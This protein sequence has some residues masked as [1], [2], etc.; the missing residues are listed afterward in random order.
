MVFATETWNLKNAL[1]ME[2]D[3]HDFDYSHLWKNIEW[4]KQVK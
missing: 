3:K 4:P 1:N 2:I